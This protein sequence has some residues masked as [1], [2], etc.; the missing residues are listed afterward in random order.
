[1]L[2]KKLYIASFFILIIFVLL[3]LNSCKKK[4]PHYSVSDEMREYF[5]FQKGSYWI[6]KDAYTGSIDSTCVAS[7]YHDDNQI[8]YGNI[9]REYFQMNF[10]SQFLYDFEIS[11]EPCSG[12]N[13]LRVTEKGDT[14]IVPGQIQVGGNIAYNPS[15]ASGANVLSQQCVPPDA[16]VYY[17]RLQNDMVNNVTYNNVIYTKIQTLDSS[18]T[19]PLRYERE[20]YFAKNVG[21]IRFN[22]T[23][24]RYNIHKSLSL[25]RK[26]VIQ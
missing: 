9:S 22:I 1:M 25:T 11:Y 7:F 15:W 26:K 17:K 2:S 5:V 3:T 16:V 14:A 23:N 10:E 21:I 12:P 20:I 24:S 19:N 18:I 4:I 6:Y 13:L 8:A